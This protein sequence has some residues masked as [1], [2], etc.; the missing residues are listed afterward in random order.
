MVNLSDRQREHIF[1]EVNLSLWEGLASCP[2]YYILI[3]G[4]TNLNG[5]G[6]FSI[7]EN[8]QIV[9]D[10]KFKDSLYAPFIASCMHM[11]LLW[12][13]VFDT[14]FKD[15][16]IDEVG[17]QICKDIFQKTIQITLSKLK[18]PPDGIK[19]GLPEGMITSLENIKKLVARNRAGPPTIT[20]L[21]L[22]PR[23]NTRIQE[24]QLNQLE[25]RRV[26][27]NINSQRENGLAPVKSLMSLARSNVFALAEDS[28]RKREELEQ[29]RRKRHEKRSYNSNFLKSFSTPK[30]S[31]Q[32]VPT[33]RLSAQS[34]PPRRTVTKKRKLK[35]P[36]NLRAVEEELSS[37]V[38]RLEASE[39]T[40]AEQSKEIERLKRQ[41]A[42]FTRV[43]KLR[44]QSK[45]SQT[46]A[47][48]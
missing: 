15:K 3:S 30:S 26:R 8:G 12:W 41:L 48:A 13:S 11:V 23:T 18:L 4:T 10:D 28:E 6:Y 2:Y 46:S 7:N 36:D 38:D 17:R 19:H 9:L 47:S 45:N 24:M 32:S 25:L 33:Q 34:V 21:D 5:H 27:N 40:V 35:K 16:S 39:Q 31:A 1:G 29:S 43:K 44:L 37:A 22:I 14:R 42:E 20:V